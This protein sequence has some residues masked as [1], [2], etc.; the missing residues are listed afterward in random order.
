MKDAIKHVVESSKNFL[1]IGKHL[2]ETA[3]SSPSTAWFMLPLVY[4]QAWWYEWASAL[5]DALTSFL[6]LVLLIVLIRFHLHKTS[7]LIQQ[8]NK[9]KKDAECET[10]D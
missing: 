7:N 6:G 9:M 10:D 5:T 1:D 4:F 2:A 8:T 3:A